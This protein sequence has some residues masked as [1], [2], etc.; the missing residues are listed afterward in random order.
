[1][2]FRFTYGII[3]LVFMLS[4]QM[5][6][7]KFTS[8]DGWY[9]LTL[10][11]NWEEYEEGEEGTH[12]FFNAASWTGNLR[13]TTLHWENKANEDAAAE[14]ISEE[15]QENEGASLIRV[16]EFD[17]AFYKTTIEENGEVMPVY[18]WTFGKNN[19]L[20]ICSFTTGKQHEQDKTILAEVDGILHS[21][22]IN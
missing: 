5:K 12:A 18:N 13:I 8:D 11:D 17:G 9:S 16:G 21:I 20:F 7:K 6:T 14:F 2:R 15:V 1:M 10:P 4:C 19:N 22:K 3:V